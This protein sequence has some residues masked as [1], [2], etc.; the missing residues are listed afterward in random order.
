MERLSKE[1]KDKHIEGKRNMQRIERKFLTLRT[2]VKRLARKTI[3]FSKTEMMQD[4]II[5][6]YINR[7]E[8]RR[9]V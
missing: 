6:L 5:G 3:C 7:Y 1:N 9:N 2:R 8:F 4:T